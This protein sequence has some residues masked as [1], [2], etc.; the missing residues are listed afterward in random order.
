MCSPQIAKATGNG[1]KFNN[2]EHGGVSSL[3]EVLHPIA[4]HPP[5]ECKELVIDAIRKAGPLQTVVQV[6]LLYTVESHPH[7]DLTVDVALVHHGNHLNKIKQWPS[8][9]KPT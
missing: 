3:L 7:R 8:E 4:G 1:W 9:E 2:E 6:G 5:L